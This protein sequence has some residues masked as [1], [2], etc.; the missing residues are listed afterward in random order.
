MKELLEAIR[1]AILADIRFSDL[2]GSVY[3]VPQTSHTAFFPKSFRC[4]CVTLTD[5]GEAIEWFQDN[6][7][8]T[9]LSVI[10]SAYDYLREPEKAL[11]GDGAI[12][13]VLGIMDDLRSLLVHNL[14]SISNMNEAKTL[15]VDRS[16][17]FQLLD[18]DDIAV[19]QGMTML[20]TTYIF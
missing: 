14:L 11:T 17:P 9:E 20:Y 16:E 10:V 19:R 1:A 15:R 13:G 6:G 2:Q 7:K 4:P 18:H 3:I 5:G 12:K 8:K